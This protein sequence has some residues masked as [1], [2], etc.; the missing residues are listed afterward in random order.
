MSEIS[1]SG[2]GAALVRFLDVIERDSAVMTSPFFIGD[3]VM[4][5]IEQNRGRNHRSVTFSHD[6]WLM[7]MNYPIEC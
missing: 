1:R 2:L 6:C 3:T 4:W 7:L 5:V